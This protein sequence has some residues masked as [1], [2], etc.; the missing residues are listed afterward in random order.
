[1]ELPVDVPLRR[2]STAQKQLVEIARALSQNAQLLIMDEPTSSLTLT[3]T[4]RLI[5]LVSELRSDGVSVIYISHRLE[6]IERVAD[7]VVV[8][9]DG[10]N[11]GEVSRDEFSRERLVQLMVGRDLD[12]FYA[13]A[14]ETSQRVCLEVKGVRTARYPASEVSLSIRS[15][16]ILGLAGL[17][18][19]GRS[20]L[21]QAIFGVDRARAGSLILDGRPLVV[22]SPRDAIRQ[23]IYL[24]P[25]D[26]RERGL[27]IGMTVR[28]NIT[29][30]D[31]PRYSTAGWVHRRQ[32]TK[33]AES[34]CAQLKVKT[35]GM[36]TDTATLSGG[37]QQ[38]IVL[39][40]WL[41][42]KPRVIL[43]DEPT[44]G[45]DVGAKAEVYQVMRRLAGEGVAILMI[46]SDMEEILGNSDRIA[47]MHEGRVTG[48]LA[49]SDRTQE[50]I[51]RL[52]VA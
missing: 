12:S 4:D 37:N 40:K 50:A 30:P 2:F 5:Q 20:E 42:L 28:E 15:G 34:Q 44:R 22:G 10:R 14:A 11:A 41:S 31:L 21:V 48:I 17:I 1:M 35:A 18:G 25:E 3:E 13:G 49:G 19:A 24:I 9:R 45:I 38:K 23:G 36:E 32:E 29:L 8:L 16:E 47:V 6:E 39:A 46:S 33:A 7:R 26:R 52:A 43:F 27:L 51:M